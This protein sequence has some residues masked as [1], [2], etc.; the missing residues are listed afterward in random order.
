MSTTKQLAMHVCAFSMALDGLVLQHQAIST[1]NA[2]KILIVLDQ[3]HMKY[4]IYHEQHGKLKLY[5][6]KKQFVEGLIMLTHI[7]QGYFTGT[8]PQY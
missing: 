6:R 5:L 8:G 7:L 2:D 4:H 1:H 3:F